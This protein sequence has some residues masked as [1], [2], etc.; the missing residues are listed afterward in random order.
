MLQI[1]FDG[2]R[3]YTMSMMSISLEKIKNK[4]QLYS[5]DFYIRDPWSWKSWEMKEKQTLGHC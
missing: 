4:K 3:K 1:C 2:T 5:C